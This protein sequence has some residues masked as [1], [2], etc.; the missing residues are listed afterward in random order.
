MRR[1]G[2]ERRGGRA[3][4]RPRWLRWAVGRS[5]ARRSTEFV[6]IDRA[7]GDSVPLLHVDLLDP[8][9]AAAVEAHVA[10]CHA[11]GGEDRALRALAGAL[12][13]LTPEETERA[14]LEPGLD[15]GRRGRARLIPSLAAV[16]AVA[17]VVV[18]L[19]LLIGWQRTRDHLVFAE[20]HAL[21]DRVA[22]VESDVVSDA[23]MRDAGAAHRTVV[24]I[25]GAR[26]AGPP[27]F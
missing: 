18:A 9:A 13:A 22:Q 27:N 19:A 6:C 16:L 17:G 23:S 14:C 1:R 5:G 12:E 7:L 25:V 8:E 26:F 4:G 24:P 2:M 15:R 10:A 11:C 21:R 3:W 20:V